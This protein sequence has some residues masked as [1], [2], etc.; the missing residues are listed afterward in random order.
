M[1]FWRTRVNTTPP[2]YP[3]QAGTA[4]RRP[5]RLRLPPGPS[6]TRLGS[7]RRRG[8]AR[9]HPRADRRRSPASALVVGTRRGRS[10]ASRGSAPARGVFRADGGLGVAAYHLQQRGGRRGREDVDLVV[11]GHAPR[12]RRETAA[13]DAAPVPPDVPRVASA[14]GLLTSLRPPGHEEE[15]RGDH[16]VE[17]GAS[18]IERAFSLQR[19]T[20]ARS[21]HFPT[22]ISSRQWSLGP[23]S[24]MSTPFRARVRMASWNPRE[25]NT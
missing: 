8:G 20:A 3:T 24:S 4:V 15:A 17:A 7:A 2:L 19:R 12:G 22:S 11:V 13:L 16:C 25:A 18:G 21:H 1:V 6:V 14:S 23:H 5:E 10:R 9:K